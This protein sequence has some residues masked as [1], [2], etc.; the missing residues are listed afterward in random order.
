MLKARVKNNFTSNKTITFMNRKI[1]L[2]TETQ[3]NMSYVLKNCMTMNTNEL[4]IETQQRCCWLGPESL[5]LSQGKPVIK[6]MNALWCSIA[7]KRD[8][9]INNKYRQ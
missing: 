4:L 3:S 1:M 8:V 9:Y 2:A 6:F 7:T 5:S